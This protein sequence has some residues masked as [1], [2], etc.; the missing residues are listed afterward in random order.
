MA[1]RLGC[2]RRPSSVANYQL[3]WSL[4]RRWC[5][6]KGHS[7][8][9]PSISKI[10]DFFLLW[11]WEVKKLSVSSIKAHR[12]MLSV[13]FKLPVLRDRHVLQDLIRYFCI[14]CSRR[15]SM[16]PCW[17]LDIVLCHLMSEAY[18]PLFSLSLRSLPKKRYSWSLW[19]RPRGLGSYRH[20]RRLYLFKGMISSF[21]IFPVL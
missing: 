19:L 2:S 8:S 21:R 7:V 18:E 13:V 4:Y 10:A 6:D 14:V 15:P 11:L 9:D 1:D 5:A 20:C 16:P 12:S 17:N 3:K